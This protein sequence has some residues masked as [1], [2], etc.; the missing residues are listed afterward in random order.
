MNLIPT[1]VSMLFFN[2]IEVTIN[3]LHPQYE[4][5]NSA[6]NF[7]HA[8]YEYSNNTIDSTPK[9][10]KQSLF[11]HFLSLVKQAQKLHHTIH[12]HVTEPQQTAIKEK[13]DPETNT[14]TITTTYS[15]LQLISKLINFLYYSINP[16][17]SDPA[18]LAK[19]LAQSAS[20]NYFSLTLNLASYYY[21]HLPKHNTLKEIQNN[22][23]LIAEDL[24]LD[25]FFM[26][27]TKDWEEMADEP[28]SL[29]DFLNNYNSNIRSNEKDTT[30]ANHHL[31]AQEL[32]HQL[33]VMTCSNFCRD[34][35]V[36]EE[37][38]LQ[39]MLRTIIKDLKN[40]SF[41]LDLAKA[42]Y[43]DLLTKLMEEDP[44]FQQDYYTL[45]EL[46]LEKGHKYKVPEFNHLYEIKDILLLTAKG[47]IK[48]KH[49]DA[50]ER[51]LIFISL[52][53]VELYYSSRSLA[54]FEQHIKHSFWQKLQTIWDNHNEI[55]KKYQN[56]LYQ[57]N[58][59]LAQLPIKPFLQS[60]IIHPKIKDMFNKVDDYL[61]TDHRSQ[62]AP[63]NKRPRPSL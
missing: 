14:I 48:L 26:S 11:S 38:T 17:F 54:S 39:D 51:E 40:D 55:A 56:S 13:W 15:K 37:Q 27:T 24:P 41:C 25:L 53:I 63:K 32:Q 31:N 49:L 29:E 52:D 33:D 30:T 50:V 43:K 21:Q 59:P 4:L 2:L 61:A 23:P 20:L 12:L 7:L 45:F 60:S 10:I 6:L 18:E 36:S 42:N 62:D 3:P 58:K 5:I 34:I 1:G 46:I 19:I 22:L 35:F 57:L 16:W 9:S 28:L 47:T 44:S 8:I